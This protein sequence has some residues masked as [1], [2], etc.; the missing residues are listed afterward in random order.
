LARPLPRAPS[1]LSR[2]IRD[3]GA[4]E[5]LGDQLL[6]LADGDAWLRAVRE[7]GGDSASG[8]GTTGGA[9]RDGASS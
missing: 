4:L 2:E 1:S 5:E 7:M 9:P 3:L 6:I 8:E